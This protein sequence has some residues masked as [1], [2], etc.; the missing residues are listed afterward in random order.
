MDEHTTMD[1]IV[2]LWKGE[3]TMTQ[4]VKQLIYT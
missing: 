4:T 1:E 2:K 3:E